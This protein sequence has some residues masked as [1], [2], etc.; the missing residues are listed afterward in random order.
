MIK[1]SLAKFIID[2]LRWSIRG[3]FLVTLIFVASFVC[4][5]AFQF[6]VHMADFCRHTI[7]QDNWY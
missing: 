7:F 2:L 5:F 3:I 6:L 1:K 4:W